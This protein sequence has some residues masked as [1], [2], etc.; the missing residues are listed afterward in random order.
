MQLLSQDF[1]FLEMICRETPAY[2]LTEFILKLP[3]V[4][5]D[6]QR[7]TGEGKDLAQHLLSYFKR[8]E[9]RTML[10]VVLWA[11]TAEVEC[12]SIFSLPHFKTLNN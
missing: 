6:L 3:E 1:V 11:I 5:I 8:C 10:N 12:A 7:Y 2:R 4:I 9:H